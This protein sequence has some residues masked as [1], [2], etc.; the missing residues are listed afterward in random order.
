MWRPALDRAWQLRAVGALA[1]LLAG[2]GMGFVS[3]RLSAWVFPLEA[4]SNGARPTAPTPQTPPAQANKAPTM[5]Q[6]DKQA[7]KQSTAAADGVHDKTA[8]PHP[9]PSARP[10]DDAGSR[11]ATA[12]TGG[13]PAPA[14][15]TTDGVVREWDSAD[16]TPSEPPA[17]DDGRK[18][19]AGAFP[20]NAEG[21]RPAA[22]RII[23]P[24][25]MRAGQDVRGT[26]QAAEPEAGSHGSEARMAECERRYASFRRS[27]G[28]YQPY[29]RSSRA[30]CPLL[31]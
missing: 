21:Y 11:R 31:R 16:T 8:P 12:E 17:Q 22:G 15:A 1:L 5:A 19:R 27:D 3:G 24:D 20:P 29:G 28:T 2:W 30:I 4:T 25:G 9:P 10:S 13:K 6:T 14:P 7:D 18:D 26:A 23:N